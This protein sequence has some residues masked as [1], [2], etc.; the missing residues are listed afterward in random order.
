M[1]LSPYV[2][3]HL[4]SAAFLG[5]LGLYCWLYRTVPVT[6]SIAQ[7][8]LLC[9]GMALDYAFDLSSSTLPAKLFWMKGRFFFLAVVPVFWLV[10][11][12][13]YVGQEAL[14]T[15]RRLIA[16][17]VVPVI[18][19][20]LAW[21]SDHHPLFRYD[22]RLD[23]SGLFPILLWKGGP[24]YWVHICYSYGLF[25]V[26]LIL[27]VLSLRNAHPF[28]RRQSLM[29]I[30]GALL[31]VIADLV[32]HTGIPPLP[33]Y[34]ISTTILFL[35][36][37]LIVW[38]LFRYAMLNIVPIARGVVL[39]KMSDIMIVLDRNDR[40]VDFNEAA[41]ELFG[42][43]AINSIGKPLETLLGRWPA[44][45]NQCRQLQCLND[46]VQIGAGIDQRG[47]DL[48]ITP[49]QDRQDELTGR[50]IILRDITDRQTAEAA[51]RESEEKYRLLAENISD[52][53]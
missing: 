22:Y 40:V 27:L 25:A 39:E 34:I 18:T 28:Y 6:A 23:D 45:F 31:P 29:I 2:F 33:G 35:S 12:V 9:A 49:I 44:L 5:G 17:F 36:S 46:E 10:M 8:M 32:F 24:W 41:R 14:V 20:V 19:I 1:Q 51:L 48:S 50:V 11:I 43:Q 13:R 15:R 53:L 52:V 7:V 37:V 3:L 4:L 30:S 38:A 26:S 21:T 42:L 16:L 47:Y